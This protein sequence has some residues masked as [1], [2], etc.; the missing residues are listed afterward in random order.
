MRRIAWMA[1][2]L[3]IP[4]PLRADLLVFAQG[5]RVQLPA[6]VRGDRVELA[7]PDGPKTFAR[8]DF[9]SIT[10]GHDPAA[11][12]P[13]MRERA[14]QGDAAARFEAAWWALEN[15]LTPEAVAMLDASRA[16]GAGHPPT[17][18]ALAM[19][20]ALRAPC[21]P[22]DLGP[23]REALR[24]GRF[25]V[26]EG[27]HV[28]LLHQLD[29][30][31]A[32]ERLDVAERVV[33][34]FCLTL[35]AQG[36]PVA[37]PSRRLISVCFADRGEY[38]GFL[39][40]AEASG[41]ADTQGFYHPTLRA[42]FAFDARGGEDQ[43]TRRRALANR[44]REGAPASEIDRLTLLLEL[45]RR[46][47]DLGILAHET[48]HQ[49]AVATG[50]EP[51]PDAF[52][53]WLHEGLAA[54]FEV[55]RGG[56]WAGVGRVNDLRLPDWRAIRPAPRL[57]PLLR[58]AGLGQGYRRDLYAESWALVYFLRKTRPDAFRA[59]LDLLRA[60]GSGADRHASAFRSAFGPD[61]AG[62]ETAWHRY[63][64]ELR[65]PWESDSTPR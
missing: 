3:M 42:V 46:A 8:S 2:I 49:L 9:Q 63:L 64:A 43:K 45:D 7:T 39:R 40:R 31:T 48:V 30:A 60:P 44:A 23:V 17:R 52:P 62:L 25:E 36:L 28:V 53:T 18:R 19:L 35:A 33:M 22:A 11:E 16:D 56:R 58:D 5:G 55:V 14:L 10:P 15:G 1:L 21:P 32:R 51:R 37:T 50:I 65:T 59:Y 57:A 20:D 47:I 13:A 27:E 54:Q 61:L 12:W 24:P 34:T 41:F 6:T 38:A 29:A 26:L 4:G